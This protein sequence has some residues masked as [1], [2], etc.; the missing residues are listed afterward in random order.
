MSPTQE[1][2]SVPVDN[3]LIYIDQ[4]DLHYLVERLSNQLKWPK[5]KAEDVV[6]QYKNFLRLM[7]KYPEQKTVPTPDIDEAWH[8]HI[9]YTLQYTE[10]S[11][12]IKGGYIH[13]HP[14]EMTHNKKVQKEIDKKMRE[15]YVQTAVLYELEFAE[16]YY[17]E[18]LLKDSW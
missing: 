2:L 13:H 18:S 17:N 11:K 12:N 8:N 10:D 5:K 14:K 3:A 4:L 16:P 15:A 7:C 6:R 1:R 9:L